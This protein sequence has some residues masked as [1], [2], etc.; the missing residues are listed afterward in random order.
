MGRKRGEAGYFIPLFIDE[1]F[2]ARTKVRMTMLDSEPRFS[3]FSSDLQAALA[4]LFCYNVVCQMSP[5]GVG[6]HVIPPGQQ[7]GG[8]P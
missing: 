2:V 8:A 6:W 5:A 7:F 4:L 3:D 1:V